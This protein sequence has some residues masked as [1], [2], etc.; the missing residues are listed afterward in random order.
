MGSLAHGVRLL[1]QL[2]NPVQ[3]C[4]LFRLDGGDVHSAHQARRILGSSDG[5]RPAWCWLF[6]TGS[7]HRGRHPPWQLRAGSK[8]PSARWTRLERH[9]RQGSP[10]L[11]L[12]G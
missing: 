1:R 8:P 9:Q 3:D 2:A 11:P 12:P 5:R 4:A 6:G 7:R 10:W